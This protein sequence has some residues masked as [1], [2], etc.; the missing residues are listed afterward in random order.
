V[1]IAFNIVGNSHF[2]HLGFPNGGSPTMFIC[3]KDEEA[4]KVVKDNILTKW[5]TIDK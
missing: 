5:K 3:G 4:K 1:V 2:V